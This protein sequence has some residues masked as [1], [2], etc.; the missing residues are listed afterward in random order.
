[1]IPNCKQ[2][3]EK[4]VFYWDGKSST[5]NPDNI[6]L[7]QEIIDTVATK[8][9]LVY[10]SEEVDFNSTRSTVIIVNPGFAD[11]SAWSGSFTLNGFINDLSSM[12]IYNQ[13]ERLTYTKMQVVISYER[14]KITDVSALKYISRTS[15][16][17]LPTDKNSVR[18]YTPTYDYHPATKKY[19]D[20]AI[21]NAI[22][23]ALEVSY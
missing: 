14:G 15:G 23:S 19:V 3:N 8:S 16:Y 6:A 20:D 18:S 7:W 22:T 1:M 21:S 13:G 11:I 5:D 10:S 17:Y 9:V 2:T 4:E 12:V